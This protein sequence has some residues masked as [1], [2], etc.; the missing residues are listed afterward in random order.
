MKYANRHEPPIKGSCI[1]AKGRHRHIVERIP[2]YLIT[3]EQPGL[4]GASYCVL[5]V[6]DA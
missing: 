6:S 4:L 5:E 2:T 1:K 3:H